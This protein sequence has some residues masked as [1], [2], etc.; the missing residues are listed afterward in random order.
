MDVLKIQKNLRKEISKTKKLKEKL[1]ET[2]HENKIP[3]NEL[4]KINKRES[5]FNILPKKRNFTVEEIKK[6]DQVKKQLNKTFKNTLMSER[7]GEEDKEI[8]FKPITKALKN[9]ENAV[10]LGQEK[11]DNDIKALIPKPIL[12]QIK[13]KTDSGTQTPPVSTFGEIASEFLHRQFEKSFGIYYDKTEKKNMIG[14][15]YIQI[16][17]DDIFIN[18]RWIQGTRGLWDLITSSS[19]TPPPKN[20]YTEEDLKTYWNILVET[21]A[22]Y[23][24]N[25]KS[26]GKPKSN[27]GSKYQVIIKPLWNNIKNGEY[28]LRS[29]SVGTIRRIAEIQSEESPIAQN[30]ESPERSLD[31]DHG[32]IDPYSPLFTPKRGEGLKKYTETPIE[33]KYI[34]NLNELLK[35]L[36]FIAAE[37]NAGNNNF[38][39]EK[40]GILHFFTRELEKLLD[41]KNGTEILMS[42]VS[43]L[44]KRVVGSGLINDFINKIPFELHWPGYNYLGPGTKLDE[45]LKR[46]DKP[47]NKLDEAAKEHDIFY[48]NNKDTNSRNKADEV[49]EYKAWDRVLDPNAN[50]GEKTAAY[51]TTNAMKLKRH[52]GMGLK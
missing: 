5:D 43:R 6:I 37:E 18:G 3:D 14:K 36:Y 32:Y 2:F 33:Y 47:I 30:L 10:K 17:D 31:W 35:R 45:R 38:Y 27:S 28:R 39:N 41:S 21:E 48:K 19:S 13:Y 51:V 20:N 40:L 42:F 24:N 26:K 25:D 8:A 23:Q 4:N 22:I 44:P 15:E 29:S 12:P 34:E 16:K 11:I 50:F 49:L 7:S 9:V 52:L 46:G 1:Q